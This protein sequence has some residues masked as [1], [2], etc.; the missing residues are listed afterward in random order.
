MGSAVALREKIELSLASRI[1]AALSPRP[2]QSPELVPTG[3]AE[4]DTLLNNGL[5][6]PSRPAIQTTSIS[7]GGQTGGGGAGGNF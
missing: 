1:P 3:I 7:V 2:N 5:P 6:T 4:L